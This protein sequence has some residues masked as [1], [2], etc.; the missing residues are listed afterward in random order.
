MTINWDTLKQHK[1]TILT[2]IIGL[3]IYLVALNLFTFFST[4]LFQQKVFSFLTFQKNSKEVFGFDL[5]NGLAQITCPLFLI[6]TWFILMKIS[7]PLLKH[8][9]TFLII[10]LLTLA[11]SIYF[12]RAFFDYEETKTHWLIE[13]KIEMGPLSIGTL[14]G[15]QSLFWLVL[16]LLILPSYFVSLNKSKY[17]LTL[18]HLTMMIGFISVYTALI[19]PPDIL[20]H[21]SMA[22]STTIVWFISFLIT[23]LFVNKT[24]VKE[25]SNEH[26]LFFLLSGIFLILLNY[27][28]EDYNLTTLKN[29]AII[30]ILTLMFGL[31]MIPKNNNKIN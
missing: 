20:S 31:T 29:M 1:K 26:S 13:N 4:D 17:A 7:F 25:N 19:S 5:K 21:F 27:L 24:I 3:T 16:N 28:F 8:R 9:I 15:F 11:I 12:A 30:F 22:I 14:F 2:A 23:K 6:L 10:S 18:N